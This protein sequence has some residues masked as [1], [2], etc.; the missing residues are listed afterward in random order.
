MSQYQEASQ[1]FQQAV[2]KEDQS[3]INLFNRG[4]VRSKL[5]QF[6]KANEDFTNAIKVFGT[7]KNTL[8]QVYFCRYNLGINYRKLGDFDASIHELKMA[9]DLNA[10]KPSVHNNLGLSYFEKNDMDLAIQEFNK[11]IKLDKQAVHY[12]NLGLAHFHNK[13]IDD[14]LENFTF[15]LELNETGDPTI[16]FN[17]GNAYLSENMFEQALIDYEKAA[18]IAPLNPKYHHAKGITY[19]ALAA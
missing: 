11:A 6:K 3:G 14:A 16:Y 17:R 12:N 4:L 5:N 2:L 19:E 1:H 13:Q 8:Q 9:I 15:A 18:K 10:D 7:E